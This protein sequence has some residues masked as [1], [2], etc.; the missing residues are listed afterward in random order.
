[1]ISLIFSLFAKKQGDTSFQR[2]RLAVASCVG[3]FFG[4][5]NLLNTYLAGKLD[6]AVFFPTLNIGVILLSMGCGM[7]L[8]KER[9]RKKDLAVLLL[10]IASILLLTVF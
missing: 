8:F 4:C 2:G 1:V 3:L 5:C 10:G 7:L 9:F 6:S